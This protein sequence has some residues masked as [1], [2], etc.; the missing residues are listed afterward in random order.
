[1]LQ[2]ANITP[3]RNTTYQV[4]FHGIYCTLYFENLP[5]MACVEEIMF[6]NQGLSCHLPNTSLKLNLAKTFQYKFTKKLI[7]RLGTV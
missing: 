2:D 7:Q 3:S 4:N 6:L 5:S 1:M